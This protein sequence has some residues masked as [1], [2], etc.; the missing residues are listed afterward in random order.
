LARLPESN[1]SGGKGI[2]RG[3]ENEEKANQLMPLPD[4]AIVY[5]PHSDWLVDCILAISWQHFLCVHHAVSINFSS[6]LPLFLRSIFLPLPPDMLPILMSDGHKSSRLKSP[7]EKL[8]PN[9]SF[10]ARTYKQFIP[11][12]YVCDHV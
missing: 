12:Q 10:L 8:P 11:H 3:S 5:T 2:F 9:N 4:K 6:P 7:E 1:D